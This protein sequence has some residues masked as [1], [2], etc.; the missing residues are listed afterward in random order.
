MVKLTALPA[1]ALVL[2]SLSGIVLETTYHNNLTIEERFCNFGMCSTEQLLQSARRDMQEIRPGSADRASREF[3]TALARDPAYPYR[4]CDLGEALFSAHD[5]IHARYCCTRAVELA[6]QSPP[7]LLRAAS[8]YFRV[9]DRQ[10]SLSLM[11]HISNSSRNM[12]T[13]F[14]LL[15]GAWA[16]PWMRYYGM[17]FPIAHGPSVLTSNMPSGSISPMR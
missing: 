1:L 6:P 9:N 10:A 7:V 13:L 16:F 14:S 15:I 17:A 2:G 3:R 5:I 12:T 4:W 11:A 8:F